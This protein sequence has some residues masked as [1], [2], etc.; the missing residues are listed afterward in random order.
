M[1]RYL[2]GLV[3]SSLVLIASLAWIL[4]QNSRIGTLE[5]Q[6]EKADQK[7]KAMDV[8]NDFVKL[9]TNIKAEGNGEKIGAITTPQVQKT[10]LVPHDEDNDEEHEG[11]ELA[12]GVKE[13]F[14]ITSTFLRKNTS[15]ESKKYQ[16]LVRYKISFNV[17]K[18][19][20]GNDYEMLVDIIQDGK[21]LK[22]NQ[23]H[24]ESVEPLSK[25]GDDNH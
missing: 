16:V 21:S 17:D 2:V 9:L 25:E 6:V 13:N 19:I 20:M 22:V 10:I 18:K 11:E 7:E 12:K 5:K 14:S 24:L 1:N 15:D 4:N 8:A 3:L 23:Y